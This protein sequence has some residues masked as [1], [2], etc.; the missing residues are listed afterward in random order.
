MQVLEGSKGKEFYYRLSPS[1][2]TGEST[3]ISLEI[4]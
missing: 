1:F 4:D 2:V 3:R